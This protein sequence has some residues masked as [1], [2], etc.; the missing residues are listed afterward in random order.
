ME[1]IISDESFNDFI[2]SVSGRKSRILACLDVLLTQEEN[3]VDEVTIITTFNSPN[4]QGRCH[5]DEL[6]IRDSFPGHEEKVR[7]LKY[8]EFFK[9]LQSGFE[10]KKSRFD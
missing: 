5:E 9:L 3:V 10:A 7:L 2:E 8:P 4:D 6:M 1:K